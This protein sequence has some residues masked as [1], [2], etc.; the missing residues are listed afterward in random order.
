MPELVL[1][2]ARFRRERERTWRELERLVGRAE[3][4]GVASLSASELNRLPSL[5]RSAVSSLSVALAIS[6]DKNLEEYLT[7]L[8][9]RAYIC[10]YG[11]KRR[12][13]PAVVE[14]FRHRFPDAVRRHAL[15]VTASLAILAAGALTGFQLTAADSERYY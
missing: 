8:V 12:A 2:S 10:V 14:F 5:Y 11:G 7:A 1:K 15:L 3:R 9:G 6:L 4:E 13:W